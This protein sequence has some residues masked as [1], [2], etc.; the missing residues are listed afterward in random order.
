MN[1]KVLL[2]LGIVSISLL[3][4]WVLGVAEPV[5]TGIGDPNWL[6]FL[7]PDICSTEVLKAPEV[8]QPIDGAIVKESFPI[9]KLDYSD[10]GCHPAAYEY[11]LSFDPELSGTMLV[12]FQYQNS[13][14]QDL[15]PLVSGQHKPT[16]ELADCVQ[17][18]WRV[19]AVNGD[20]EGPWTEVLSFYTDFA[21]QCAE[22]GDTSG[23]PVAIFYEETHC[24]SGDSTQYRSVIITQ[25]SV[26]YRVVAVNPDSSHIKILDP[27]TNARCW[28]W[29]E[30]V[31]LTV[32]Q[33][34]LP[35]N[36]L[37]NFV[38]MEQP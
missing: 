31:R 26:V 5:E 19:R 33:N 17:Y 2:A 20:G 7:S 12:A 30:L 21:G 18:F 14:F 35:P 34:V 36:Q 23:F 24:R 15:I 13:L 1:P 25:P 28:V 10:A 37:E 4:V 3:N 38:P 16:D 27:Q 6:F 11:Q 32:N 9:L 22:P 8:R 29:V